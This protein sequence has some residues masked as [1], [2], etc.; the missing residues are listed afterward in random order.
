MA[1]KKKQVF[2][3]WFRR[4]ALAVLL[5]ALCWVVNTIWYKPFSINTFF[6]RA[7]IEHSLNHPEDLTEHHVFEKYA[8]FS[9][10]ERSLNDISKEAWERTSKKVKEEFAMLKSYRPKELTEAQRLSQQILEFYWEAQ[11]I[12][13]YG[14]KD[15]Y[16]N[17]HYPIDPINGVH[18]SFIDFM[19]NTHEINNLEDAVSYL[20]RLSRGK[21]KIRDLQ[22]NI[23]LL[24][25]PPSCILEKVVQQI[26]HFMAPEL[27]ENLLYKDFRSK[28]EKVAY[29]PSTAREELYADIRR[30]LEQEILPAY[31]V[32]RSKIIDQVERQRE[33][34]QRV[35]E[36]TGV[37]YSPSRWN[38]TTKV[39]SPDGEEFPTPVGMFY[40]LGVA[41]LNLGFNFAIEDMPM[42]G[43]EADDQVYELRREL[44]TLLDSA[45]YPA[46]DDSIGKP[47][48]AMSLLDTFQYDNTTVYEEQILFEDIKKTVLQANQEAKEIFGYQPQPIEI[49]EM[50][51]HRVPY[52]SRF[53]YYPAS[54]D[55]YRKARLFINFDSLKRFP[56]Y[57]LPVLLREYTAPGRHFLKTIQH[58]N[59]H[60]PTF[61]RAII[62][63]EAYTA[64]WTCYAQNLLRDRGIYA[65]IHE[66]IGFVHWELIK[67]TRMV[68]DYYIHS[69][70][71][72]REYTVNYVS[73][74]A[75]ITKWEAE[76]IVD[77]III[78]PSKAFA[79]WVG[80][81]KINSLRQQAVEELDEEFNLKE[82]HQ[83]VLECGPAP[84]RILEQEVEQYIQRNKPDS[85]PKPLG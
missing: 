27:E 64:G 36:K 15:I 76:A 31:K 84:M 61:R 81:K 20:E 7:F 11:L 80:Y 58:R 85:I 30:I 28:V 40:Y 78:H 17:C 43:S 29:M 45:G 37:P 18:I 72:T 23:D 59:S 35:E 65:S 55:E 25:P 57:Q 38:I 46:E 34:E 41:R 53:F 5:A 82:F 68:A 67:A 60:L 39:F 63:I 49:S 16:A 2:N 51:T 56:K 19:L 47:L 12:A 70:G 75:G 8:F 21:N 79:Y 22:I 32:L 13:Q 71:M 52:T 50:V 54:L 73:Y 48:E 1:N 10:S 77:W 4:V 74:T 24:N 6:E 83:V 44:R 66:E 3:L 42:L 26:D 69:Q 33:K 62:N 14:E 9:D